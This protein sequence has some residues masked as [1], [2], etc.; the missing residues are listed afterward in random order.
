MNEFE[1]KR[2]ASIGEKLSSGGE[3]GRLVRDFDWSKTPLG[4]WEAWPQSLRTTVDLC[5]ASNFPIA[6]AWGPGDVQIYNDGYVPV[7]GGKHPRAM[8]QSFRECWTEAW[9]VIGEAY[10]RALL[11]ETSFLENQ[12]IFLDRNGY[13]EETFFSFSFSPIRD[14]SGGIGGLFHPVVEM[15]GKILS[16]RRTRVLKDV[17]GR[18]AKAKTIDEACTLTALTLADHST[19][20]PFALLY[21]FDDGGKSARLIGVTGIEEHAKAFATSMDKVS[22]VSASLPLGEVFVSGRPRELNDLERR[23]GLFRS[24]PYPD[25]PKGALLLP[26]T[27]PGAERPIGVLVAGVSARLA[28]DEVYRGFYDLLAAAVTTA[29]ANGRA[30]EEERRRAEALAEIDRAKTAFFG[31]VSHEFRTPLTLMLGPMEDILGRHHS[32]LDCKDRTELEIVHRNGQRLLKLVNSLL[33]FSRIEAGRVQATYEE[34]DLSTLTTDLASG[35]RSLIERAGMELVVDCSA[36]SAPAYVDRDMW[37]KIVLNLLSNAFKYTLEGKITVTLHQEGEDIEFA[38]ADTGT[39]IPESE[40][41]QLFE[42][43]HRV[44]GARGRT[45]EGTGIG[46]ALVQELVKLQS[47]TVKVTSVYG[48][49][50]TFTVRMPLGKAHLPEGRVG[51]SRNLAS[52]G[53]GAA[54]F[55][56][57]A[58]RWVS[59]DEDSGPREGSSFLANPDLVPASSGVSPGARILLADD[60][61]DMRQYVCKLL[62]AQGWNV[63][64]VSDGEAALARVLS[65]PPDLILTDV[66]MPRLDGFG[67][68]SALKKNEK[69]RAIPIIMLSARAGS[70]SRVEGMTAGADDYLV[71]PFSARE[72]IARVNTHLQ[73]GKLRAEAMMER[74]KLFSVF[75]QAPVPV[76]VLEGPEHVIALANPACVSLLFG[77]RELIGK[78]VRKALPEV[79]YQGFSELLDEVYRTGLPFHGIETLVQLLQDDGQTK[80]FFLN[81]VYQPMAN[82][83]G[84]TEGIVAVVHDVTLQVEARIR[85]RESEKKFKNLADSM[86]QLI[87]TADES[88]RIDYTNRGFS[89]FSGMDEPEI[90]NG[91]DSPLVH[92][93]DYRGLIEKWEMSLGSSQLFEGEARFRRNDGV[94]RWFL[95]RAV[96]SKSEDSGT[97]KWF[98]SC[99][100]IEEQKQLAMELA[101]S[102][103]VAESASATKSRFLANMSH[104]IRTPLGI[105]LGF[106]EFL[107][108]PMQSASDRHECTITIRRNAAQL[109]SLINELLDISKI[110]ADH[111][112]IEK[113]RF[114]LGSLI[115]DVEQLMSFH[116]KEKGVGLKFYSDDLVQKNVTTDAVRL[117]QILIN[118]VGNALKF[119]EKGGVEIHMSMKSSEGPDPTLRLRFD[120]FDTGIGLSPE[121]FDRIW[122]PFVQA[123]NSTT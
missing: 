88:G 26:I 93:E 11:G 10:E 116:A 21:L 25:S 94:Y 59:G 71:K 106:S 96:P 107:L 114:E 8:G 55:V 35:F 73:I 43:F 98:G 86:P 62:E 97:E 80:S 22:T 83:R 82:V 89:E 103:S 7:C 119:T 113:T 112:E 20:V 90:F 77:R 111:L 118:I 91:P 16:E 39:G 92:P 48:Q 95:L 40:L 76:C 34:T 123:D 51:T 72:L 81:F 52:P 65:D 42:R 115:Q 50:S 38:V 13:L 54:P 110:E 31:N 84:E 5:L 33:D 67:L 18:T 4:P 37:E 27:P 61:A 100:D 117:R 17:A 36:L 78:T 24:G 28:L 32:T 120:V 79:E 60:N 74:E 64:A 75:M 66:M 122:E 99:T 19:D 58:L 47:G 46:L 104:E 70:E 1:T 2:Q 57:E 49:G 87:W 63:I 45:H 3:T 29:V 121:Q 101:L 109:S 53:L 108:E 14:E 85:I 6:I 30:F 56:A 102:K 68:L 23:F 69:T 44:E 9:G 105:I 12:R 41:D 15:T